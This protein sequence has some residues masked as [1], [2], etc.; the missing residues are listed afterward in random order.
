MDIVNHEN[1]GDES[2]CV[3]IPINDICLWPVMMAVI[4]VMVMLLMIIMM[5]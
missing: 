3:W 2:G 4:T 1:D 5:G